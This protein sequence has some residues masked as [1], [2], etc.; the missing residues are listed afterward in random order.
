[1]KTRLTSLFLALCMICTVFAAVSCSGSPD[2]GKGSYETV[3][4]ATENMQNIDYYDVDVSMIM[5]MTI[6][7][8]GTYTIPIEMNMKAD[9]TDKDNPLYEMFL[10]MDMMGTK[11]EMN[12]YQDEEWMYAVS[13]DTAYKTKK[14]AAEGGYASNA[15]NML[16]TLPEELF[17]GKTMTD[18]GDGS[19]TVTLDIPSDMF[20]E[21]YDDIVD[22]AAA[23]NGVDVEGVGLKDTRISITVKDGYIREYKMSFTM[24][25]T[26]S[27]METSTV[28]DM[29]AKYNSINEKITV[30]Y[31]DGYKD[32]PEM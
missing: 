1:M 12:M 22:N 26:V 19:S 32:F 16:K 17:V 4:E 9:N 29:T 7:G 28:M 15:D 6:A 23:T 10:T 14:D 2:S 27:G 18:N 24:V 31:P 20:A 13:A 5:T 8:A 25:M 21:I 30:N 11:T 3:N